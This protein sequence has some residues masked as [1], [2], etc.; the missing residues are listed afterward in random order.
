LPPQAQ[1]ARRLAEAGCRV[2][3]S[4]LIDRRAEWSGNT[5]QTHREFIYRQAY[6]MGRHIIGY[7]V[8]KVLAAIDYFERQQPDGKAKA[9]LPVGV[10]GWGEGA[11][12]A[13][14]SA[15]SDQ[16]IESTLVSGY[17][18]PR[19]SLWTEPV[20]RNVWGLLH[21]YGDAELAFLMAQRA[22]TI[23][24][25]RGPEVPGPVQLHVHQRARP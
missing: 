25:C 2:L 19:E 18:A 22:L 12:V 13:F 14:Y 4:T 17:F 24:A 8:Q 21:Q 6:F 1:L 5:H 10:A 11:L 20:Y 16:R 9:R 3:V 15:A 7:E 23:E